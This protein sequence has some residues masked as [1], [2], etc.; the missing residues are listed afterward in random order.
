MT[1]QTFIE[2]VQKL[3]AIQSTT[4][5]PDDLR[6]ALAIIAGIISQV[7]GLTVEHFEEHGKPS[8]LAYKGNRRPERFTVLLNGHVDVV[9][10]RPEQFEP[11]VKEDKLY[12][13]GALDMKTTALLMTQVFCD[14]APKVPYALGLQMV[15]DEEVGGA[16]G[17]KLHIRQG[18]TADF[19]IAGEF[20]PP[21]KICNESRGICWLEV[22][23]AGQ[24][25]HSAY[26]W[27]GTN[28]ILK[29]QAFTQKL[30]EAYPVPPSDTWTTTVNIASLETTNS[31]FNRVPDAAKLKLDIRYVAEDP[32]FAS[33][34]T[35]LAFMQGLDPSA[36]IT[37]V[38][39]EPSHFADPGNRLL[40]QLAASLSK[41]TGQPT[42]FIKKHGASDVRYYSDHN[43]T[44]VVYGLSGSGLHSDEEYVL[45]S[46]VKTYRNTLNA[47]LESAA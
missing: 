17:T 38:E 15:T 6:D 14:I 42:E 16:H 41:E 21:G 3:I 30:L 47:F 26:P 32:V 25:A 9:P 23:F 44:A 19:V 34:Q 24:A 20:T 1:D 27:N 10:G 35:M 37:V 4:D 36:K 5:R 39:F 40:K 28:A 7:P 12:G 33:E 22:D 8:L 31:T 18:V 29:A 2:T 43:M 46:S 45:L 13:R 11:F